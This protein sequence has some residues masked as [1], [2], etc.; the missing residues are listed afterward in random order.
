MCKNQNKQDKEIR[1][2]QPNKMIKETF[3]VC[4]ML[5]LKIPMPDIDSGQCGCFPWHIR[6]SECHAQ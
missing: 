5:E 4:P 6:L 2:N 3:F 1:L